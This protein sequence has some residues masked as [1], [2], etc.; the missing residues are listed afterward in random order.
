MKRVLRFNEDQCD[1]IYMALEP[2]KKRALI[3]SLSNSELGVGT[4]KLA[5]EYRNILHI[6]ELYINLSKIRYL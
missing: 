3:A 1:R 4:Y 2:D 6:L 5:Q